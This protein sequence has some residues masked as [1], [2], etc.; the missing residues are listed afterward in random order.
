MHTGGISDDT[1]TVRSMHT[2]TTTS[3]IRNKIL[4]LLLLLMLLSLLGNTAGFIVST[5]RTRDRILDRQLIADADRLTGALEQNERNI[6]ESAERL[7]ADPRLIK[8][9]L[10]EQEGDTNSAIVMDDRAITVRDRF[11]VDQIMVFNAD[12]QTRVNIA[13][14]HLEPLSFVIGDALMCQQGTRM[15]LLDEVL[16]T[17]AANLLLVGCTPVVADDEESTE[18]AH[19]GTIYSVLDLSA[20]LER[21]RTELDLTSDTQLSHD[22]PDVVQRL[23]PG[24][25]VVSVYEQEAVSLE[26]SRILSVPVEMGGER[27]YVTLL[28]SEADINAIA[29][30]G[31][32]VTLIGSIVTLLLLIV[33]SL[34]LVRSF[35]RPLLQL[36]AVA[37]SVAAGELNHRLPVTSKDEIGTLITAFNTMVEGL[38]QREQAEHE[39]E[40]AEHER[41]QAERQ[42]E[43]AER[44]R[45]VARAASQAKS[46]FLANMSHEFRTPLN[47]IIGYGELLMDD[48]KEMGNEETVADLQRILTA[49]N[50]LL[51]LVDN[52][53]DISK[54]ESG[55]MQLHLETF[56]ISTLVDQVETTIRSL[57]EK[58]GNTFQ[59][60]QHAGGTMHA[61][62]TK[63]RQ[64]IFN[65]L[66]N[67]NKFTEQGTI[68]LEVLCEAPHTEADNAGNTDDGVGNGVWSECNPA[69]AII[70]RVHDT[71][72]GIPPEQVEHIFESFVQ[73][74]VSTTR[75]YGGTGLGL[76][77]TRQF[78]RMMGGDLTAESVVGQGSVFTIRLPTVVAEPPPMLTPDQ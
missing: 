18:G 35:T 4:L 70:F 67:A 31:L 54:I 77:I 11:S 62:F 40:Q 26:G 22:L 44:E 64:A 58:K 50:H 72:I 2:A 46:L 37:H 43:Q 41:E 60:L 71:G 74:D 27:I 66:S 32:Q 24:K 42:R 39:R 23:A 28:L 53:L 45:E 8:A 36:S 33:V 29:T 73:A 10:D 12:A 75:R 15:K 65:L 51:S 78:C 3:S 6:A 57:T 38:R 55:K 5:S 20:S 63:V 17:T 49:G 34:V 69:A 16:D 30:S 56:E 9:L 1:T 47:A 68:T 52:V 76:A 21:T 59:V 7:A 13:P 14:S 19:I 25:R 48:A 61:D